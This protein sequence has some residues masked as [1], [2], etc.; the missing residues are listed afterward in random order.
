MYDIGALR[1]VTSDDFRRVNVGVQCSVTVLLDPFL[2]AEELVWNCIVYVGVV[3]WKPRAALA[4]R[5]TERSPNRQHY[6]TLERG[7]TNESAEFVAS[8]YI[9]DAS[10]AIALA[11]TLAARPTECL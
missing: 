7:L 8:G 3:L 1:L 11:Q 2:F 6:D 5:A 9:D 10:S 4:Q